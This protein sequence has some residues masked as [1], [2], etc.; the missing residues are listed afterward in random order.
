MTFNS[1]RF[2]PNLP[3]DNIERR[4]MAATTVVN[5]TPNAFSEKMKRTPKERIYVCVWESKH[6]VC[7]YI[8]AIIFA[9]VPFHTSMHTNKPTWLSLNLKQFLWLRHPKHDMTGTLSHTLMPQKLIGKRS[10]KVTYI[11]HCMKIS[12][13]FLP[14]LSHFIFI[15]F[16][17]FWLASLLFS[18]WVWLLEA[19]MN[20]TSKIDEL[21]LLCAFLFQL[22]DNT[23]NFE[24]M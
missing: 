19:N 13:P 11:L 2:T 18:D 23:F 14:L 5:D 16:F 22:S 6:R 10:W 1:S 7:T 17:F 21:M 20:Q 4:W 8:Y 24:I 15:F 12:T 3:D 9:C